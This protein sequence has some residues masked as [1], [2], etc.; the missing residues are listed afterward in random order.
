MSVLGAPLNRYEP[1]LSGIITN[2][3]F[4]S[5]FTSTRH[6]ATFPTAGNNIGQKGAEG[7]LGTTSVPHAIV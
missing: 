7:H 6:G 2:S 3:D 5:T 1:D 4:V